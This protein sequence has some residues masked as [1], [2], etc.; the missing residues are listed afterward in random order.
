[1]RTFV[2]ARIVPPGGVP[3]GEK[4]STVVRTDDRDE[5]R[6]KGAAALG[7]AP[8]EVLVNATDEAEDGDPTGIV[9][10]IID[11]REG[12]NAREQ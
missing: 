9:G 4:V 12:T 6:V 7:V 11:T 1:M 3:F 2:I 10:D 5:A 8:N